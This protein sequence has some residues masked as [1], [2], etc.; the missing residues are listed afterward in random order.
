M[1]RTRSSSVKCVNSLRCLQ[2][3]I[4]RPPLHLH[5]RPH[6]SKTVVSFS[7][8]LD[9]SKNKNFPIITMLYIILKPVLHQANLFG[10]SQHEFSNVRDWLV[11][12]RDTLLN[13]CVRFAK[14]D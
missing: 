5:R 8:F 9:K 4:K 7:H 10:N 3:P 2:Q 12:D 11:I 13:F 6:S 14:H 1:Y